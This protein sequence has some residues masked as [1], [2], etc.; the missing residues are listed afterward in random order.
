MGVFLG[1]GLGLL[2]AVAGAIALL[3]SFRALR[4]PS[5]QSSEV[6]RAFATLEQDFE[7]MQRRVH[8]ELG[9]ISRLKR[10]GVT[11]PPSTPTGAAEKPAAVSTP[12][13]PLSR[14]QLLA[15]AHQR[16]A[17]SYGEES[18]S[19]GPNGGRR[20]DGPNDE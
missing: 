2:G 1:V 12:D 7:D 11:I 5:D 17:Y 16:G 6:R 8:G 3:V 14:S 9:R 15:R 20:P 18:H 4:K 13:R 10:D 19:T